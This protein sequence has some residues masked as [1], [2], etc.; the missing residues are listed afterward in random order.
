MDLDPNY[1]DKMGDP[2][3]RF[4]LD[5][6]EH[7]YQQRLYASAVQTKIAQ[8]MGV[9]YEEARPS[10][11]KYNTVGYQT[12][13]IQGGAVMG[14]SP[15]TS[16]VDTNLQHWKVPNLIVMGASAFPQNASG[17]PTLTVLAITFRAADAF[18]AKHSKGASA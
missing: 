10:R 2:L 9:K 6:T 11:A 14:S 12:T 4:T 5:W 8:A 18:I 16:V 7:E 3:L 17:N 1:T 13:H 15:E